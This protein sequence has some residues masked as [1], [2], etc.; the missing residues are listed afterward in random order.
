MPTSHKKFK[1]H[2]GFAFD[3]AISSPPTAALDAQ[4]E[5]WLWTG[6]PGSRAGHVACF[7]GPGT[8]SVPGGCN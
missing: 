4:K 3:A 1:L 2:F 8:N 5:V 7:I 6:L